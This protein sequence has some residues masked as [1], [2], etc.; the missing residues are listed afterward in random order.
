MAKIHQ[1]TKAKECSLPAIKGSSFHQPVHTD[2]GQADWCVV[3]LS[4]TI[5]IHVHVIIL[6][7]CIVMVILLSADLTLIS[8]K[9]FTVLK[10]IHHENMTVLSVDV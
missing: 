8:Y 2:I 3:N 1:A 6:S 4:L 10:T 9:C 7:V 5:A